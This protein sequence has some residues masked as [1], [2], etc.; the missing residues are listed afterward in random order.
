MKIRSAKVASIVGDMIP[1]GLD[2]ILVTFVRITVTFSFLCARTE[3]T[4]KHASDFGTSES[5]QLTAH[6]SS[7]L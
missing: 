3:H 1:T 2:T 5:S 7:D 4:E 6:S